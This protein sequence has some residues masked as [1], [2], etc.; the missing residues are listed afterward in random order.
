LGN[1]YLAW[2]GRESL[3]FGLILYQMTGSN[4]CIEAN[5]PGGNILVDG[6]EGNTV[7]L[8]PDLRDTDGHWFYWNFRIRRAAGRR[9]RFQFDSQAGPAI[10]A[11]GPAVSRD[12]G[13]SW[14]WLGADHTGIPED[15]FLIQFPQDFRQEPAGIP[16]C[17][18]RTV[19]GAQ[20]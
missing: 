16:G 11:R 5:F 6:I 17:A 8:R 10:G 12:E 7:H 13:R 15:E 3:S 14:E 19:K 20:Q 4:V 18:L 2:S 9:L 1:E